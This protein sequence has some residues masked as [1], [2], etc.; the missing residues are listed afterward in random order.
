IP[1]FLAQMSDYVK[2]TG[3]LE[4]ALKTVNAEQNRMVSLGQLA[5]KEGF[6]AGQGNFIGAFKDLSLIIKENSG[7]IRAFGWIFSGALRTVT[8]ILRLPSPV[9]AIVGNSFDTLRDAMQK[10]QDTAKDWKDL[11]YVER[12]FRLLAIVLGWV[13]LGLLQVQKGLI[14][15]GLWFG[16]E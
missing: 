16:I 3:M 11:T 8:T 7:T 15:L 10:A 4:A 13:N 14:H 5:V 6:F 9:I 1:K 2:K 12:A